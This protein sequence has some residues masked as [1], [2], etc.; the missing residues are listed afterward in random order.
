MKTFIFVRGVDS[1]LKRRVVEQLMHGLNPDINHVSAIRISILDRLP[2][3]W[4][5]PTSKRLKA[6]MKAADKTC[7]NLVKKIL[8]G[9]HAEQ[10]IVI[11]NESILPVHWQSYYALSEK[12]SVNALAIGIDVFSDEKIIPEGDR[13]KNNEQAAKSALFIASVYKYFC[14]KTEDIDSVIEEINKLRRSDHA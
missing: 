3:Y 7:K 14:V 4:E 11:D 1:P 5:P 10:F 9:S 6:D 2:R 13:A 8:A 12:V